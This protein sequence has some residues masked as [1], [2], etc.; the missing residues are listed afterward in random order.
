MNYHN[1]TKD[2]LKN[3]DGVRVVLWVS[4]CNH[5]CKDCQNPETWDSCSGVLFDDDAKRELFAELQKDY[6]AGVTFSGGDPLYPGNREC[7]GQLIKQ[8][9]KM[10]P[11]KTVWCYTGYTLEQIKDVPF[12]KY[13]DV[14]VDGPFIPALKEL[15][16]KW[17]GSSNQRI[18][19]LK[20]SISSGKLIVRNNNDCEVVLGE[21]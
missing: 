6:V 9:H 19:M 7:V 1:I 21:Y 8:I 13:I 14:L 11:H 4:G 10:F 15:K 3:G 5:A 12:L 20:K 16:L 18:I 17:K 2:D